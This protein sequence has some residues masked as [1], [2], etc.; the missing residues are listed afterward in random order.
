MSEEHP[1]IVWIAFH[2]DAITQLGT[3]TEEGLRLRFD[4][5]DTG[6]YGELSLAELTVFVDDDGKRLVDKSA[7][8]L[9]RA[10][11]KVDP[12]ATADVE[13]WR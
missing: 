5:K 9:V 11:K 7:L 13:R 2:R 12:E 10:T 3:R 1:E 4:L 8:K 6:S